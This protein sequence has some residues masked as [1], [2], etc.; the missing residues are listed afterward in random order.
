MRRAAPLPCGEGEDESRHTLDRQRPWPALARL[1]APPAA[2]E[3]VGL[4][5][6][7]VRL[8]RARQPAGLRRR[9]VPEQRHL[10]RRDLD[11]LDLVDALGIGERG[12]AVTAAPHDQLVRTV[13]LHARFERLATAGSSIASSRAAASSR[14]NSSHQII[15]YAVFCLK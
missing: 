2:D 4:E 8:E 13:R 11:D 5:L 3:L 12:R 6:R 15:S 10:A 7:E 9:G 1:P 14:L